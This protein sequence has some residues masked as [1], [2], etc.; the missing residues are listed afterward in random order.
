MKYVAFDLGAS[1]G[2][3]FEG[4]IRDGKLC[5]EPLYGFPNQIVCL[6][7]GM[8]WDFMRIYSELCAGLRKSEARGRVHSL[9][10]DSY[11][12]DF[13]LIDSNG[14]MLIPIRSYRDPRT[15]KYWDEIFS[16]MPEEQ[17][18]SILVLYPKMN[19]KVHIMVRFFDV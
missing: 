7:D 2:K 9:G 4:E 6:K 15:R 18:Y 5:I 12:N 3:L 1:S 19:C 17:V 13:S 16:L 14:E 10:V 8:Y 11:N